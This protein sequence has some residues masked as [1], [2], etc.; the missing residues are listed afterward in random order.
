MPNAAIYIM[1]RFTMVKLILKNIK[2]STWL[3][4]KFIK[5]PSKIKYQFTDYGKM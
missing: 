5:T 3:P 1:F 2:L 4:T